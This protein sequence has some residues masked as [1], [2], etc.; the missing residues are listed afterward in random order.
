MLYQLVVTSLSAMMVGGVHTVPIDAKVRPTPMSFAECTSK[1][2]TFE[3]ALTEIV[4]ELA[5]ANNLGAFPNIRVECEP[6]LGS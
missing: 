5:A 3:L 2:V 4:N 1:R 6:W